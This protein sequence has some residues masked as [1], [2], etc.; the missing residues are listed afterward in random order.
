MEAPAAR[1]RIRSAYNVAALSFS[2]QQLAAEIRQRRSDFRIG[3]RPDHRQAIADSWPQSLDDTHGRAADWGWKPAIDLGQLVDDMLRQ[4]RHALPQ[5]HARRL[6]LWDGHTAPL[7]RVDI[8][9]MRTLPALTR[10]RR[11]RKRLVTVP[12]ITPYPFIG[13]AKSCLDGRKLGLY[14]WPV[15]P[16]K[17]G[18][19]EKNYLCAVGCRGFG[20]WCFRGVLL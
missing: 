20:R 12:T 16:N 8:A 9:R 7:R 10:C 6:S 19:H 13:K 2:P 3:Y 15:N 5:A 4:H 18:L 11:A 14:D 1:V 17:G